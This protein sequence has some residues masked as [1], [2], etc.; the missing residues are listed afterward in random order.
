LTDA[1]ALYL[2]GNRITDIGSLAGHYVVDN[3][4]PGYTETFDPQ[5]GNPWR[6]T[7]G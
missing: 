3:G 4:D 1:T 5:T 7:C 2:D 6:A